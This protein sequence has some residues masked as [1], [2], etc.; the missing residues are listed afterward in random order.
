MA[1]ESI[2]IYTQL[3]DELRRQIVSGILPENKAIWSENVLAEKYGIC[4]N[5]V[6]RAIGLLVE[7]GLLRRVRGSGTYVVPRFQRKRQIRGHRKNKLVRYLTF[8]PYSGVT[9]QNNTVSY[10][11][12][13][14]AELR[15]NGCDFLMEHVG[16]DG[17]PDRQ[18]SRKA[19]GIIFEGELPDGFY[20]RFLNDIPCVGID[21][22]RPESNC[23]WIDTGKSAAGEMAVRH[24]YSRGHRRIGFLSDESATWDSREMLKGFRTA[25]FELD[26]PVR[27]DWEICWMRATVNGELGNESV[28][29][30]RDYS[31]RLRKVFASTEPPTAL[32]C[33]DNWRA[34]V[35]ALSLE[36]IGLKIPDDVSIVSSFRKESYPAYGCRTRFTCCQLR[37]RD[38]WQ[39]SVRMLLELMNN[40]NPVRG[41]T[42]R[43]TPVFHPGETVRTIESDIEDLIS[44]QNDKEDLS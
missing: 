12:D 41:K 31:G 44:N 21:F 14:H 25:M 3:E 32:V 1:S 19:D 26:L 40:P 39:E 36:K 13:L 7:E 35:T 2:R 28:Y 4:R 5:T 18:R 15:R 38:A 29:Q 23:C 8:P 11:S 34:V 42:I 43:L 6:R 16:P 33:Y 17:K 22:I 10:F 9:F 37:I 27:T 30:P 24:L 20:E